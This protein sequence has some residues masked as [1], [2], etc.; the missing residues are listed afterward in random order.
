MA[1][2]EGPKGQQ[3]EALRSLKAAARS[4]SKKPDGQ[5]YEARGD[6]APKPARPERKQKAAAGVLKAGTEKNPGK[7]RQAA[8]KAPER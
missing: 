5:G 3:P 4:G 8:K 1:K 6:T 7:M 2:Q